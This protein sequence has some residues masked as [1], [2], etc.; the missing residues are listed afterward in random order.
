MNVTPRN[1]L[2]LLRLTAQGTTPSGLKVADTSAEGRQWFVVNFGSKVTDLTKG[3]RVEVMGTINED[4]VRLP[5]EKDL[6]VTKEANILLIHNGRDR[7]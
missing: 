7:S 6:Y 3:M 4:I 1:D 5:N 2:V